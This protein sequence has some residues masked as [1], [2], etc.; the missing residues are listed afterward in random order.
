MKETIKKLFGFSV[1]PIIVFLI[2]VISIPITTHFINPTEYGKV[3]MFT[4][5]QSILGISIF[6]G[7][8]QGFVRF[9]NEE[10]DSKKLLQN[11]ILIPFILSLLIFVI[12]LIIP[13][14][15]SKI[16]F[17]NPNY[18]IPI[19][20]LGFTIPLMIFEKFLLLSI[21]MKEKAK[22]YSFFLILIRLITFI[23]TIIFITLIRKDF[24]S[25]V[26]STV[27]GQIIGDIILIITYRK[28]I[29][30]KFENI[31]KILLKK[32]IKYSIPLLLVS[33]IGWGLNSMD[34]VFLRIYSTFEEIGYYNVALKISNLLLTIQ[35]CFTTFWVP[36][37]YR[38]YKEKVDNKSFTIVSEIVSF[39]MSIIFLLI[40]LFKD[41]FP[42]LISN[43][44][45]YSIY[46]IP[47]LLL[48]PIMYTISETTTLG[49]PF[50]K[51]SHLNIIV[52]ILSI[53]TNLILNY[54]LVPKMGAIGAAIGTG[55]SYMVF[56][57]SRTIISRKLWYKFSLIKFFLVSTILLVATFINSFVK[58][59]IYVYIINII[60]ILFVVLIYKNLIQEI[61]K[62]I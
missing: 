43:T 5:A 23:S 46:I 14:S 28:D 39:V 30:F 47:F 61:K 13:G 37:A 41:L 40:L 54:I 15:I 10:K 11:S 16:L 8:D 48:Y 19:Y 56:F 45:K 18:K 3:A 52:S 36:T 25:I 35:T 31:D 9:F 53:I 51:K 4:L 34:K 60:L 1:G 20:V 50:S 59:N 33:L 55:I 26:Y 32:L 17:G 58:S 21:R 2:G 22:S 12:L 27:I 29:E 44:Y 24:L 38:W 57:W 7:L 62:R 49:I 6:L 42:I